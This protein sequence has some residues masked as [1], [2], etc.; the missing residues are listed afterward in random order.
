MRESR[1]E[2]PEQE[3]LDFQKQLQNL[4]DFDSPEHPGGGSSDPATAVAEFLSRGPQ[5]RPRSRSMPRVT[6][7][8]SRFLTLPE[9]SWP[10]GGGSFRLPRGRS[11]GTLGFQV[12]LTHNFSTRK[13]FSTFPWITSNI[14]PLVP[15]VNK[16]VCNRQSTTALS[17][18]WWSAVQW[19][20]QWRRGECHRAARVSQ[21]MS[22]SVPAVDA[23]RC[24]RRI[25]P[26]AGAT[27]PPA[28]SWRYLLGTELYSTS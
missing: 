1:K 17:V 20:P 3:I 16:S 13:G 9:V 19:L 23:L 25:A 28:F 21:P 27:V 5:L 7:E 11:A 12:S 18:P 15:Y 4:P 6:Y 14:A 22:P 10:T 8:S 2:N 24:R 26:I